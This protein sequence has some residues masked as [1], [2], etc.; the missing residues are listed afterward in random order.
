M[1]PVS[2]S[3]VLVPD[4]RGFDLGAGYAEALTSLIPSLYWRKHESYA[5]WL[6]RTVAPDVA[7]SGGGLGFSYVAE[8]Y[9]NF[10]WYGLP[11][12]FF[13]MGIVFTKLAMRGAGSPA[14][15]DRALAALVLLF[16]L[17]YPRGEM[18]AF[19][20][21]VVWCALAPYALVRFL[22]RSE[23]RREAV[24]SRPGAQAGA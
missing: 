5:S 14:P 11:I 4:T 18:V 8:A 17:P 3:L 10:G 16:I 2:Y 23:A 7:T 9:V 12:V 22:G 13:F 6:T 20:N 24:P 19:L 15:A 21:R 1:G